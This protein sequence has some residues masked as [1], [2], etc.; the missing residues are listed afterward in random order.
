MTGS[1]TLLRRVLALGACAVAVAVAVAEGAVGVAAS[2]PVA[3]GRG[4]LEGRIPTADSL[5]ALIGARGEGLAARA[6][7]RGAIVGEARLHAAAVTTAIG[8]GLVSEI[9]P[10][11]AA[12]E[13]AARRIV[14]CSPGEGIGWMWLGYAADERGAPDAEVRAYF[15]R[16]SWTAPSELWVME[17]RLPTAAQILSRRGAVMSD[18]VRADLRTLLNSAEHPDLLARIIGPVYPW[19]APLVQAEFSRVDDPRRRVALIRSFGRW[20]ANIA[21]CAPT[22]FNDWLYRGLLGSC[23]DDDRIP[24][25]DWTRPASP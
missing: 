21:G 16:S 25:F 18:V 8:A 10:V 15:E 14:D 5:P 19:I 3:A 9:R 4:V 23:E 6:C 13:A 11:M 20:R 22:R 24:Q 2:S 7:H 1:H 17:S 12:L